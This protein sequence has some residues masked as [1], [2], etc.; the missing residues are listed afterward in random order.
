MGLTPGLP[1]RAPSYQRESEAISTLGDL[2]APDWEPVEHDSSK[3]N[4]HEE[5]RI[6]S[7]AGPRTGRLGLARLPQL[8]NRSGVWPTAAAAGLYLRPLLSIPVL[9]YRPLCRPLYPVFLLCRSRRRRRDTESG[10]RSGWTAGSARSAGGN[11]ST[12]TA[13]VKGLQEGCLQGFG[14]RGRANSGVAW[15]ANHINLKLSAKER[16]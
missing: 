2:M 8:R 6:V 13:S 15:Q 3:E 4:R 9:L 7:G 1:F 16:G 5:I 10:A 11:G 12:S 14:F